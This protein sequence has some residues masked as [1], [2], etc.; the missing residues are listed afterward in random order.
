MSDEFLNSKQMRQLFD[1]LDNRYEL[2]G[3]NKGVISYSAI[4]TN[5][6]SAILADVQMPG[7]TTIITNLKNKTGETLYVNDEV[8]LFALNGSLN[9]LY[10]A[11]K[12]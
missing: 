10:I 7:S 2:K 12:K 5:V 6:V 8:I 3:S 1:I 9:N 11:I 4:V